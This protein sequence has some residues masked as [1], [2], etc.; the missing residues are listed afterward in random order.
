MAAIAIFTIGLPFTLLENLVM[1]AFL[2]K[3]NPAYKLA[4][5]EAISG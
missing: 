3:L 1:K 5:K 4:G 2:H